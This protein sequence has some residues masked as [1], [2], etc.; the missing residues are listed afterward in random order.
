MRPKLAKAYGLSQE[1]IKQ[2]LAET[3]NKSTPGAEFD[4]NAPT[5]E[6]DLAELGDSMGTVA[7]ANQG[8]RDGMDDADVVYMEA[9]SQEADQYANKRQEIADKERNK[10]LVGMVKTHGRDAISAWKNGVSVGGPNVDQLGKAD[11]LEWISAVEEH[12][13]GSIDDAQLAQ[14]LRDI[15]NKYD[16]NNAGPTLEDTNAGRTNEST[17]TQIADDAG[18]STGDATSAESGNPTEQVGTADTG[19]SG[20]SSQEASTGVV[21]GVKTAPVVE[22]RKRKKIDP[23]KAKT[24]NPRFGVRDNATATASREAFEQSVNELTGDTQN[25]RIHVFDNEADALAAVDVGELSS[26]RSKSQKYSLTAGFRKT[27]TECL[28]RT[29]S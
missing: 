15:E 7:S 23:K 3:K 25:V 19:E 13:E 20:R 27:R 14:D 24:S 10:Q 16:Q 11:L 26:T 29:L 4:I 9:R 2:R 12:K 17:A 8:A 5:N 1:Q 21:G 22:V 28:T 6:V 18:P